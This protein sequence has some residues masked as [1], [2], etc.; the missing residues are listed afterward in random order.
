MNRL[1]IAKPVAVISA[2]VE[3]CSVRSTSRL[4]GLAKGTILRLLGDVGDVCARYHDETVRGLN[5][6]PIQCDEI[7]SFVGAKEKHASDEQKAA[8]W[9]TRGRGPAWTPIRS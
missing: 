3:G 1:P 6:R 5:C 9:A 7:W 4:T 8:G 2:L